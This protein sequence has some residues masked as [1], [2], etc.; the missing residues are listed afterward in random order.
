MK[1]WKIRDGNFLGFKK[2]E[3]GKLSRKRYILFLTSFITSVSKRKTRN[4]E[5]D[6]RSYSGKEQHDILQKAFNLSG[7][8]DERDGMTVSN[9]GNTNA[10]V[11]TDKILLYISLKEHKI[12]LHRGQV[13]KEMIRK[14]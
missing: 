14:F 2:K 11:A 9:I 5:S 8:V 1:P 10:L 7:I 13:L 4:E 6:E 12:T 3:S